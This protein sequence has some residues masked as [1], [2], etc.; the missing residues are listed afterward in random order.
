MPR[1][2][3]GREAVVCVVVVGGGEG[4][5][6][7]APWFWSLFAPATLLTLLTAIS[8]VTLSTATTPGPEES[9]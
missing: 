7:R 8:V 3:C 5:Q 1:G 6:V 9:A 4:W 2:A